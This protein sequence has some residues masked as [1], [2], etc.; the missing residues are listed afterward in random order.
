MISKVIELTDKFNCA[1]IYVDSSAVSFIKSLKIELSENPEYDQQ[2]ARAQHEK[3]DYELLVGRVVPVPFSKYGKIMLQHCKALMSDNLIAID[4][5]FQQ[6][7]V[8]CH[9]AQ[10]TEGL[11]HKQQMSHSDAFDSFLLSLR[12]FEFS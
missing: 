2:I 7:L 4:E 9:T 10:D 1:K 5:Q 12:G 11:L 8:A 6:L 3:I